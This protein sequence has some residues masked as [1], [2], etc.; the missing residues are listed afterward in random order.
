MQGAA[1]DLARYARQSVEDEFDRAQLD[2]T[3]ERLQYEAD[4]LRERYKL[5]RR[6]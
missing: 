6:S 4:L 3:V 2:A 5:L 1:N